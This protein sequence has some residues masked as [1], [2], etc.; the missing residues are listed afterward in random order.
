MKKLSILF[1]G[2]A[3]L[4]LTANAKVCAPLDPTDYLVFS[5]G[6]ITHDNNDFNGPTGALGNITLHDFTISKNSADSCPAVVAGGHFSLRSGYVG[7]GV[8]SP[9][10]V[11]VSEASLGGPAR[12]SSDNLSNLTTAAAFFT[13]ESDSLAG[14]SATQTPQFDNSGL[15]IF[16]ANGPL[17]VFSVKSLDILDFNLAFFGSSDPSQIIV[18]NIDSSDNQGKFA[19]V[20]K[21]MALNGLLP[22]QVILNFRNTSQLT[23]ANDGSSAPYGNNATIGIGATIL[24]PYTAVSGQ[25]DHITGG[26]YVG[27]L[28]GSIQV[29]YAKTLWPSPPLPPTPA[30]VCPIPPMPGK[31]Q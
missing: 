28:S 22:G 31:S 21:D 7:G 16:T 19:L 10:S 26:L 24:A 14:L 13:A 23:I 15:M 8:D 3:L 4:P 5:Q 25:S 12:K 6:S 27:S 18:V 20:G 1:L 2:T 9:Y 30:P 11:L 17:T 29:N